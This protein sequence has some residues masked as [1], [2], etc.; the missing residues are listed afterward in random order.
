MP[1]QKIRE[2]SKLALDLGKIMFAA[3]VVGFF[4]PGFSGEVSVA[5]FVVGAAV[6]LLLFVV[7]IKFTT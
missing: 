5:S 7:G 3:T 2:L 4:V 6:T 1:E